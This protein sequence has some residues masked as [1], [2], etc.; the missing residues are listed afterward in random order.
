MKINCCHKLIS[1]DDIKSL[2]KK[3]GFNVTNLNKRIIQ[4]LA[5]SKRPM[6]VKELLIVLADLNC[7]K[8]SLFRVITKF[9]QKKIIQE[10]NLN[11][12]FFRY[13]FQVS[14]HELDD[15]KAKNNK[16]LF[17]T[18]KHHHHHIRCRKC[19]DIQLIP[20]CD[21]TLIEKKINLLGY[22]FLEH[23]LEFTGLCAKCS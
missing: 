8:S 15:Q 18:N 19:D 10:I 9:K 2:L 14:P 6:S 16:N 11:E 20:S 7:D 23:Y 3:N 4:E 17:K 12:G 13:E 22:Q 21:L 1:E 5:T